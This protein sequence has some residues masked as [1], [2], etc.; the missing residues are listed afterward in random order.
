VSSVSYVVFGAGG[1]GERT[2]A[3]VFPLAEAALDDAPLF[4]LEPLGPRHL[5]TVG[6]HGG[7]AGGVQSR[8]G[9]EAGSFMN[10]RRS[11]ARREGPVAS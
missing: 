6:S 8:R 11:A 10:S 5:A 1:E 7:G 4:I 9:R 2:G 3:V